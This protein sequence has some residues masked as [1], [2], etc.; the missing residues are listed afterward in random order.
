MFEAQKTVHSEGPGHLKNTSRITAVAA[1]SPTHL[2][3]QST[4]IECDLSMNH[5]IFPI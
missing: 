3:P 2:T 1:P 5:D 4:A